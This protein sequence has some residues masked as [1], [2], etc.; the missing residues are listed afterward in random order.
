MI[1][2]IIISTF[3]ISMLILFDLV[4]TRDFGLESQLTCLLLALFIY[5]KCR[6]LTLGNNSISTKSLLIVLISLS[7]ID[8]WITL[9]PCLILADYLTNG[10]NNRKRIAVKIIFITSLFILIYLSI[11]Y[12]FFGNIFPISSIVKKTFPEISFIENFK[13]LTSSGNF[14]NHVIKLLLLFFVFI[15]F[16]FFKNKIRNN[17][18][19]HDINLVL[20]IICG[21]FVANCSLNLFFNVEGIREWYITVPAF[22]SVILGVRYLTIFHKIH[23]IIIF[24]LLIL[25][26]YYFYITRIENSPLEDIIYNYSLKLRDITD[27]DS[28]ILQIDKSGFVGFFSERKIINGDGIVNSFEYYNYIKDK[29]LP[30]YIKE[31]NISYYSTYLDEPQNGSED[32]F[33]DTVFSNKIGGY[34]FIIPSVNLI[35]SYPNPGDSVPPYISEKWYLFKINN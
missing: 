8:Y 16:Y 31:K 14:F 21:G 29:N 12:Y 23:T 2:R 33:I 19:S 17:Q 35:L 7:R 26:S 20:W 10:V 24:F 1:K 27:K 28:R 3:I 25:T 6:D 18:S 34:R 22:I 30:Q 4:F 32:Y 11:N 13:R 5:V 15:T 9:T